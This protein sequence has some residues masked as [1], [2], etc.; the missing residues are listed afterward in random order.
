M[1]VPTFRVG[2]VVERRV[3]KSPWADWSWRIVAVVPEAPGT[4]DGTVL[5][6]DGEASLIYVGAGAVEFHRVETSNYRD[7]LVTG[8]PALWVTLQ[9]GDVPSGIRL[10]SVTADPAEG[11][12]MTEAGD[13]LVDTV[14]MPAEMADALAA[15]VK[16]H[17]VERV[18]QKRKRV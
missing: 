6:G 7:N 16:E 11:E 8:A 10:L 14:T 15:F 5:G 9:T 18:F 4:E 13:L 2:V 1:S 17:H 3:S 12:M